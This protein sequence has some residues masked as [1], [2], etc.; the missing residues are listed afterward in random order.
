[1]KDDQW[2][3]AIKKAQSA[4]REY[5]RLLHFAEKEYIRR[6]GNHPSDVDDDWWI[7]KLHYSGSPTTI[8]EIDKSAL[9]HKQ[10]SIK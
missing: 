2:D 3:K 6:Y 9:M 5:K 4:L 1:M 7:D 10:I 8:S